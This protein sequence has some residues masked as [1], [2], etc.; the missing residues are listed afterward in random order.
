[1]STSNHFL[2]WSIAELSQSIKDRAISPV[3]VTAASLDIIAQKD[4]ELN[5]FITVLEEQSLNAAK[6]AEQEIINGNYKGHLHGIPIGLKDL[7]Y[8]KGIKTTFGSEIYQDFVPDYDAEIVTQLENAGAIMIGKLN[9]HGFA[10]GTTGDRSFFGPVKNPYDPSKITGGSSSGSAA[11]VAAFLCYGAIG[12]DT[13]GSIRMPASCCGIVGM[14][15][16]FGLVSK[17]GAIPLC[18]TLDHLGPMTRTVADNAIMLNVL[19]GHDKKDIYSVYSVKEDYTQAIDLG[20]K[21]KK[22]GIPSS[23]YFDIIHPEVQRI[24]DLTVEKLKQHGA[25]IE[26]IDL[27]G[28]NDLLAAQQILLASEAYTSLEKLLREVPDRIEEEVRGRA[29]VGMFIQASEYINM[30]KIKHKAINMHYE[31]LSK[32]NVIM[33]PTLCTLPTDIGQR[34]IDINGTKEHTRILARLTG[35]S[36]TTGFPAISVSG[37]MSKSGLPVGIQFIGKPFDEGQLYQ[38]AFALE[39]S[40][41]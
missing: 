29:I 40:N 28:M 7:I 2:E 16:T 35:P 34:E 30:L 21:G 27:P 3:E 25:E 6:K 38:F 11:A 32:V 4:K 17:Y 15:P 13:G 8:T 10:Y 33:T 23:F 31:A 5:S 26:Y 24:F 18:Q 1:M 12:S 14:K 41:L 20:I 9:M 39:Q 22:I 37:G 19:A 36:N